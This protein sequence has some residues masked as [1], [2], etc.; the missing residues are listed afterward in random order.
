MDV[1]PVRQGNPA[2]TG[3]PS[4]PPTPRRGLLLLDLQLGLEGGQPTVKPTW[5]WATLEEGPVTREPEDV[6]PPEVL[7]DVTARGAAYRRS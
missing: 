5:H 4:R 6:Y 1:H 2:R 7:A 3:I